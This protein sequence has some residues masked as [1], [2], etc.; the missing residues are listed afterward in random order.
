MGYDIGT[1]TK[2]YTLQPGDEYL[3]SAEFKAEFKKQV[4]RLL[5]EIEWRKIQLQKRITEEEGMYNFYV[6]LMTN[7]C[8]CMCVHVCIKNITYKCFCNLFYYNTG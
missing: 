8:V 4:H 6:F 1:N 7:I 5:A 2:P 3:E